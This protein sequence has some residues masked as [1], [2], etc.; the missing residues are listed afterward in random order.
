[1]KTPFDVL[2]ASLAGVG[3]VVAGG[4]LPAVTR[5]CCCV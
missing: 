3:A 5:R 1:M 2:A 4:L